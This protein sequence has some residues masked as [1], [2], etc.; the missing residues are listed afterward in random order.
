MVKRN[1]ISLPSTTT[2]ILYCNCSP[3]VIE[4]AFARK[5]SS[6]FILHTRLCKAAKDSLFEA[7]HI[8]QLTRRFAKSTYDIEIAA[9]KKNFFFFLYSL[10]RHRSR[11]YNNFSLPACGTKTSLK[12]SFFFFFLF[13]STGEADFLAHP[14]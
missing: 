5:R 10:R 7:K 3:F 2:A 4:H 14:V 11:G 9:V 1:D 6:V 8:G 12:R 13:Y